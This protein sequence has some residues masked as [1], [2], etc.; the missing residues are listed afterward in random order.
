MAALAVVRDY[1]QSLLTFAVF[2]LLHSVGAREGFKAWLARLTSAFAVEHFW[3]FPYCVLSY[4]V[5]YYGIARLH[6]GWHPAANVWV[7]VY[8]DWVRQALLAGHLGSVALLYAAF[9]QS[10]YL[11]FWGLRQ[12]GRG[13]GI[14]WGRPV[15]PRPLELFGTQR[16]V[17]G[18]VYRWVRH[19]MLVGGWLFLVTSGPSKNNLIFAVLYASYMLVG[20][21]FE[22]RRLIRVFGDAYRRYRHEVGAFVPRL[23]IRRIATAG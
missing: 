13:L 11:E 19:P 9:L 2:G 18:G 21:H 23:R 22:E 7:V 3:R 15:S 6:W 14:L 10:D 5:Y 4:L 1:W 17:V 16:L 8:P 12:L 20:A